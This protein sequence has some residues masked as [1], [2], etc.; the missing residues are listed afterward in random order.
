MYIDRVWYDCIAGLFRE[1]IT[2]GVDLMKI[3]NK[4][5]SVDV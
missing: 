4:Q 2:D 1:V 5:N 3:I